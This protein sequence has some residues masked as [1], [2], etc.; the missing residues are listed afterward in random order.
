MP[1]ASRLSGHLVRTL[2]VFAMLA[3][4][5][6]TFTLRQ[7][8]AAAQDATTLLVNNEKTANP[9][10]VQVNVADPSGFGVSGRTLLAPPGYS[11]TVVGAN[12]GEPRFMTFDE[13]GNLLVAAMAD[14]IVYRYPY[15]DGKLGEPE[16]LITGLQQPSSVALFKADDGEYLYVGETPQIS[17]YRYDPNGAAGDQ[18]VV[19]PDLPTDGHATRTVIFG[20]D[21]K[22]YL[23]VGSS[24]NICVEQNPIRAAISVAN[25]DGSGLQ[26]FAKGLRNA[27]G[28]AFQ[29]GG[30]NLW[31]TVNERDNQ[32]NEIP[33]DLVTIVTQGANYGWPDCQPPD[34]KPQEQGADCSNITPPTVGIQAH[35]APLG[36]AFLDG[37]GVPA[38][39]NGDLVVVQHG[40]W[41]RQPPAPPKLLLIEFKNGQPVG[42][43]DFVT[44][45]QDDAGNRWGRPAGV[46]LAPDG[47]LIVSDDDAGLLY[48]IA[49][50]S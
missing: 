37:D 44:G 18:E 45:W 5:A 33:P 40:S 42:A 34:A 16:T 28:L 9:D 3:S 50:T 8:A 47:A 41:N 39:L 26:V 27:V 7:P 24:C 6:L 48:R 29:P 20:P 13:A 22:L 36:L 25:P 30:N 1:L 15:A 4:G 11:V 46:V 23:S 12:L 38:D 43:H 31:A 35:S 14:G 19:I 49:A 2:M 21:G 32:G 10:L 17:R